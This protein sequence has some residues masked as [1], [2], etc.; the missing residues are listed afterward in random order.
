M[1]LS[2]NACSIFNDWKPGIFFFFNK[3]LFILSQNCLS[4]S[5]A[6]LPSASTPVL[7]GDAHKDASFP[8]ARAIQGL[9]TGVGYRGWGRQHSPVSLHAVVRELSHEVPVLRAAQPVPGCGCEPCTWKLES[10]WPSL[11]TV[12]LRAALESLWHLCFTLGICSDCSHQ[13]PYGV[14]APLLH[15]EAS[16]D[17]SPDSYQCSLSWCWA[18]MWPHSPVVSPGYT[19]L[20]AGEIPQ[21]REGPAST[22]PGFRSA[23][24]PWKH[25]KEGGEEEKRVW[26]ICY[27]LF[28]IKR[29]REVKISLQTSSLKARRLQQ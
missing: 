3:M 24:L 17:E 19:K 12:L 2:V 13:R 11:S 29:G 9:D 18:K 22:V 23:R 10:S 7:P 27:L 16:I 25:F 1:A 4:L 14:S 20:G 26:N 28:Q 15:T 5:W 21:C 8:H 6:K